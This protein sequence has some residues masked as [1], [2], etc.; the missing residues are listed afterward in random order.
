MVLAELQSRGRRLER[1]RSRC[2][3]RGHHAKPRGLTLRA[4]A[5]RLERCGMPGRRFRRHSHRCNAQ[6]LF[7]RAAEH[8]HAMAGHGRQRDVWQP[9]FHAR[10]WRGLL[11][12][13]HERAAAGGSD[14]RRLEYDDRS[15][16]ELRSPARKRVLPAGRRRPHADAGARALLQL[17]AIVGE[18]QR[19]GR[20]QDLCGERQRMARSSIDD[21]FHDRT[22]SPAA[23]ASAA[24]AA[25]LGSGAALRRLVVVRVQSRQ[26][27]RA[28][29]GRLPDRND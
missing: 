1:A 4:A 3:A 17:A 20:R 18:G 8:Q 10:L 26:W 13:L 19:R 24:A 15:G 5:G 25:G 6:R 27:R 28:D 2:R 9:A 29:R 21:A 14:R 11:Y 22:R 12:R 23:A 16:D 7:H